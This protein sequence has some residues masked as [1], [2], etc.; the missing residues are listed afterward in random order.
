MGPIAPEEPVLDRAVTKFLNDGG[1]KRGAEFSGAPRIRVNQ[2]DLKAMNQQARA[3]F[4]QAIEL[5]PGEVE[6]A[7][8]KKANAP[9]LEVGSRRSAVAR[10]LDI[11]PIS[12]DTANRK[13]GEGAANGAFLNAEVVA[14]RPIF[15]PYHGQCR[16]FRAPRTSSALA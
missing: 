10:A 14:L 16:C 4:E 15:S 12:L 2:N 8:L 11:A 5:N 7:N 1:A 13:R 9:T 3:L 6:R